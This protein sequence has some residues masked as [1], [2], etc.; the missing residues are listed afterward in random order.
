[1]KVFHSA[2]AVFVNTDNLPAQES[3]EGDLTQNLA[4]ARL[5]SHFVRALV[6]GGVSQKDV[7]VLSLYR[8]QI[9]VLSGMLSSGEGGLCADVEVLTADRSQ[10]RDKEVVVISM[11]RSNDGSQVSSSVKSFTFLIIDYFVFQIGELLKDWR[12]INVAF[13]RAKSKLV[14]F[15][16]RKTLQA[17]PVMKEFFELMDEQGWVL[18]LVKGVDAWH[19]SYDIDA[20]ADGGMVIKTE[21]DSGEDMEVLTPSGRKRALFSSEMVIKSENVDQTCSA[22]ARRVKKAKTS[23]EVQDAFVKHRP[24]LRDIFNDAK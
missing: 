2:K 17:S 5:I 23:T 15:G 20:K 6:R 16:S 14:I 7:G 13:T 10:G 4:E 24:I 12:R 8:Q 3:R 1:M 21:L 18:D 19:S 11:V 22:S 9:K